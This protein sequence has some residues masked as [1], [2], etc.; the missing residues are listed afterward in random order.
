M[1]M[2]LTCFFLLLM[3]FTLP[4]VFTNGAEKLIAKKHMIQTMSHKGFLLH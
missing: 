4:R 2:D 3:F 1:K